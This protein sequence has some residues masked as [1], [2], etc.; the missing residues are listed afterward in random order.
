VIVWK[1][2]FKNIKGFGKDTPLSKQELLVPFI[3]LRLKQ[4]EANGPYANVS[5]HVTFQTVCLVNK[6][7]CTYMCK[8]QTCTKQRKEDKID[9][10]LKKHHRM[11]QTQSNASYSTYSNTVFLFGDFFVMLQ[12]VLNNCLLCLLCFICIWDHI[13]NMVLFINKDN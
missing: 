8:L 5:A 12:Y 3:E 6:L 1:I 9:E 4:Q 2:F 10:I 13:N 11:I 7:K